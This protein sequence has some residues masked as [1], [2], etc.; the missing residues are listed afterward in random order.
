VLLD[1]GP[2]RALVLGLVGQ[3]HRPLDQQFARFAHSAY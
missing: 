2:G 3:L 1:E